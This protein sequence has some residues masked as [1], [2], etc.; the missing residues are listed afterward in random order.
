MISLGI[1]TCGIQN[2]P[3]L[4]FSL[5]WT[6]LPRFTSGKWGCSAICLSDSQALLVGGNSN[7]K[8]ADL[9]TRGTAGAWQWRSIAPMLAGHSYPGIAK[10]N[11]RVL[12]AGGRCSDVEMLTLAAG[13]RRV[14]GQW[15]LLSPLSRV[16]EYPFIASFSG[17]ILLFSKF[18]HSV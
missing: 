10:L 14:L 3:C 8:E 4:V 7:A 2:S 9:L 12:V 15:T 18:C 13:K 11:C 17:R 5:R 16:Y 1:H 6:E